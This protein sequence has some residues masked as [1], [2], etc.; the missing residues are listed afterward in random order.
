[1]ET[2]L[3][4]GVT[5]LVMS[6]EFTR[7]QRFKLKEIEEPIYVRNVNRIFNKEGLIEYTVE[8][9]IYYQGYRERMEIDVIRG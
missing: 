5:E 4:S 8:V 7:K 3:D 9:N 2:L 6:L 1:M